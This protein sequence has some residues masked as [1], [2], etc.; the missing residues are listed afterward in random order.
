MALEVA[1]L[2]D[3]PE[4]A[5]MIA[6]W[7]WDEWGAAYEDA[8]LEGWTAALSRKAQR[9]RV[10]CTWIALADGVPCGSVTLEDDGVEPRTELRPD[11]AG[12]FVLPAYRGRG[13]GSAL[14][15]ACEEG[16]RSFGERRLYLY[17]SEA[18]ALYARLGWET[19][20]RCAFQGQPVAVMLRELR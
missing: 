10:P 12:L 3:H 1:P 6:R 14:V 5:E 15:R 11:L 18:E 4:Y 17:T 16:A 2:A 9:D 13:I 20:E 8:S 19:I 7:H